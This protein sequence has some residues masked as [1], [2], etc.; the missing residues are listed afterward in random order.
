MQKLLFVVIPLA[1]LLLLYYLEILSSRQLSI[2]I[3]VILPVLALIPS[4]RK[5]TIQKGLNNN[6]HFNSNFYDDKQVTEEEEKTNG[7]QRSLNTTR[8]EEG[9]NIPYHDKHVFVLTN[10]PTTEWENDI[11]KSGFAKLLQDEL[12]K[13]KDQIRVLVSVA[14][15]TDDEK[16]EGN[17]I[18]VLPDRLRIKNI[19]EKDVPAL[20]N[21]CIISNQRSHFST[22]PIKGSHIF[23]NCHV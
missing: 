4:K 6:I 14:E 16:I 15:N 3:I 13:K 23:I 20:V 10:R 1:V 22:E 9:S 7:F 19:Q 11:E 21:D 2:L 8:S 5:R 17:T 12:S 18:L